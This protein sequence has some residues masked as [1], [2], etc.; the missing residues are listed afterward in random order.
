[1]GEIKIGDT[2]KNFKGETHK[3]IRISKTGLVLTCK[4]IETDEIV[5]FRFYVA[6][7]RYFKE[8]SVVDLGELL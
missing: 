5:K 7:G 6:S 4:N 8:N 2:F 3:V 1:M